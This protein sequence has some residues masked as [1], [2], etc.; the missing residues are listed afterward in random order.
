MGEYIKTV[1][2]T[3]GPSGWRESEAA[4]FTN[5]PTWPGHDASEFT[6][7]AFFWQSCTMY[8]LFADVRTREQGIVPIAPNRGLPDDASDEALQHLLGG[9]GGHSM[10]QSYDDIVTVA[11]KVAN[12]NYDE[13]FGFSWLS[14]AELYAVDYDVLITSMDDPVETATLRDALGS[15]YFKHLDQLAQLG[16]P[17]DVRILFCFS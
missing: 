6:R 8:S 12:R 15:L 10:Y 5:D 4:V 14:P 13:S 3:R 16:S 7:Y 11:Q 9:W 2:E 1:L 17:N